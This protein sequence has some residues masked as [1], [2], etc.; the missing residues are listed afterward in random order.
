MRSILM[1]SSRLYPTLSD[2]LLIVAAARRV[3]YTHTL[4]VKQCVFRE[5]HETNKV[6]VTDR[7]TA[8]VSGAAMP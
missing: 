2:H 6:S 1:L 3:R 7:S 5:P 4:R 8:Q